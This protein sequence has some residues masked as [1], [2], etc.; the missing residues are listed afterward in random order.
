MKTNI[1]VKSC[2]KHSC[3]QTHTSQNMPQTNNTLPPTS[4]LP[5]NRYQLQMA[6][7]WLN[8]NCCHHWTPGEVTAT[9]GSHPSGDGQP[10]LGLWFRHAVSPKRTPWHKHCL[11][12]ELRSSDD[13]SAVLTSSYLVMDSKSAQTTRGEWRSWSGCGNCRTP[14]LGAGPWEDPVYLQPLPVAPHFLAAMSWATLL[15]PHALAATL[16]PLPLGPTAKA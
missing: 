14:I 2:I 9:D 4:P 11:E 12:V 13:I 16:F 3:Q 6:S 10:L 8:W 7:Q 1:N 15:H 5:R